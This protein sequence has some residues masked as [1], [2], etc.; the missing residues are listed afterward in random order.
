MELSRDDGIK[1][2]EEYN[3]DVIETVWRRGLFFFYYN[4]SMVPSFIYLF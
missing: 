3:I 4:K 2:I 1:S